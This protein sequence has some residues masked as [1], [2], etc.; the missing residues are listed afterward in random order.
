MT[1]QEEQKKR[2]KKLANL[3]KSITP[4]YKEIFILSQMI[5]MPRLNVLVQKSNY[6]YSDLLEYLENLVRDV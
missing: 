6:S 3:M 1:A 5:Q 2:I 4:L